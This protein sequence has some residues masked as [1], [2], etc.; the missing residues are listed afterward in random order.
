VAGL[1]AIFLVGGTVILVLMRRIQ[2]G[3]DPVLAP[4]GVFLSI[5]LL[6]LL[7]SP[8]KARSVSD[9]MRLASYI[10]VYVL[11]V[12]TVR[13]AKAVEVATDVIALSTV[14][15]L[16]VGVFQ[17]FS[18]GGMLTDVGIQLRQITSVFIHPNG[19]GIYLALLAPMVLMSVI[20][21]QSRLRQIVFAG[22]AGAMLFFTIQTYA[23][24]AWAGLLAGIVIVGSIRYRRLIV[25]VPLLV[26]V[27]W[28]TP[29]IV[30]KLLLVFTTSPQTNSLITRL[31]LW[32]E[33]LAL[34]RS[35][36]LLG[37]GL[38]SFNTLSEIVQGSM[39]A[40]SGAWVHN[41]YLQ[42][43]AETG[44][45][46]LGSYLWAQ[47]VLGIRIVRSV[48]SVKTR[49]LQ[50]AVLGAL[51]MFV[52]S[53]LMGLT[54]NILTSPVVQWYVWAAAGLAVVALRLNQEMPTDK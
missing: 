39:A 54:D 2:V 18:G 25:F 26:L 24:V 13:T 53:S 1:L 11:I 51:S 7:L 35:S 36:P 44:I 15:P 32:T 22:L 3:R 5:C 50:P 38:G 21:T 27:A 9:W 23:R 17:F 10:A 14:V 16:M 37:R 31:S 45:L 33:A 29:S 34:F 12:A 40:L 41:T 42:L 43:L 4:Y 52:A 8:D 20:S 46:G 6:S 47:A 48:R 19:Y 28:F 30:D 49:C